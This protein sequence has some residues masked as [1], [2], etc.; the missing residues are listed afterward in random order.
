MSSLFASGSEIAVNFLSQLPAG[1]CHWLFL[2]VTLVCTESSGGVGSRELA[3]MH[4]GMSPN[5]AATC[6]S[7]TMVQGP[8]ET[9][10]W[11]Q[12]TGCGFAEY[13]STAQNIEDLLS[14]WAILNTARHHHMP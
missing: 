7:V 11:K 2:K 6:Q 8:A 14:L 9:R 13:K 3:A 10:S 4:R 5:N 12:D 1:W